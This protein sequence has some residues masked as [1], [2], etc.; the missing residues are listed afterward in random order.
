MYEFE[1]ETYMPPV[2]QEIKD[3]IKACAYY[4]K[5]NCKARLIVYNFEDLRESAEMCIAHLLRISLEG[6]PNLL[7]D[8]KDPKVSIY[9]FFTELQFVSS[10]VFL[11]FSM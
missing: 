9:V 2:Q 8:P 7:E 11:A 3:A 1:K 6:T 5:D 4:L 10:L